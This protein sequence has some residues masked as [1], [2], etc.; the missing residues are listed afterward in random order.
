MRT[1]T[2]VTN[3]E[4]ELRDDASIVS[5]TD[6]KGI[7]TYVNPDFVEASGFT[8]KELLGQPHNLLRHPDMPEEAFSDMWTTLKAGRPWTGIVK[9]RR[10][11]GDHYWVIANATPIFESGSVTG[12]MSVRSKPTRDV[13]DAHAAAYRLFKEGRQGSLRIVEGKAVKGA[14]LGSILKLNEK[15]RIISTFVVLQLIFL[16]VML[17]MLMT[18]R[19]TMMED[20]QRA[21]RFAVETASGTVESLG[22][23][24][25]S[26]EITVEEAQK[27]AIAQLRVMRYDG[28]EYFWINDMQPRMVMHP[29]KPELDG[30]DLSIRKTRTAKHSSL[31]W[32]MWCVHP[33]R[34][35]SIMIGRVLAATSHSKNFLRQR[36]S[37]VGMG[38]RFRR[39]CRRHRRES[40]ELCVAV[41]GGLAGN[42]RA[43]DNDG[44][45][46]GGHDR[47]SVT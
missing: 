45:I 17:V 4:Y 15:S 25:A 12:Y 19:N 16:T 37:A 44:H 36:V 40:H 9:N 11:N 38:D 13:I 26:G 10:K 7:I 34:A 20:R 47:G 41:V 27:R 35:S 23:A 24:A 29:V 32:S 3:V 8:E 42:L 33:V 14:G 18:S 6:L 22:K 39:I 46:F 1:N 28:K 30:K 5:K 2:P 21:T 43:D 31:I